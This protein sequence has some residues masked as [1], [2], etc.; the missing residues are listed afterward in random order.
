MANDALIKK[1]AGFKVPEGRTRRFDYKGAR[2]R[3]NL[4]ITEEIA[5][6]LQLIKLAT[7]E[8]K[9]T[10]CERTLKEAID[11]KL[12]EL[13]AKHDPAAWEA[14]VKVAKREPRA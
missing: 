11:N 1:F 4:R 8:D 10:Y 7:G 12:A 6:S 13:K 9:N 3:M 5:A 2:K 14:L